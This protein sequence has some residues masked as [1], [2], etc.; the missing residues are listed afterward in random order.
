MFSVKLKPTFFTRGGRLTFERPTNIPVVLKR[1]KFFEGFKLNRF[2][3]CES[4]QA[5]PMLFL[6]TMGNERT[7][8]TA[9]VGSRS[10][11]IHFKLLNLADL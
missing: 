4:G 1:G 7:L 10:V 2:F 8:G 6:G 3:E 11:S 9:L 5:P